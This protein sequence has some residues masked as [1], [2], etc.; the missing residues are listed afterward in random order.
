MSIAQSGKPSSAAALMPPT[1]QAYR[2]V[3]EFGAVGDGVTDD[4]TAIQNAI[5]ASIADGT[6]LCFHPPGRYRI[7]RYIDVPSARNLR[8][9]GCGSTL[10]YP[11]DQVVALDPVVNATGN[12]DQAA[13]SGFLLRHCSNVAIEG[14]VFEGGRHPQIGTL[15]L[16]VGAYVRKS[17]NL[18]IRDS[19]ALW[20][21]TLIVQEAN[22]DTI[23][24]GDALAATD[25]IVTLTDAAAPFVG[26][27]LGM[28]VTVT[29]TVN[30]LNTGRFQITA[31]VSPTQIRFSNE[32]AVT[33][34]SSFTWAIDDA[35]TSTIID[36]CRLINCRGGAITGSN[37][38]WVNCEFRLPLT[39]D[40]TGRATSFAISA[41]TVTLVSPRATWTADMVGK[42]VTIA[43]AA[44]P[45]NNGVFRILT[46]T[47]RT[48]LR[49]G[50]ITYTNGGGVTEL[51]PP[52]MTWWILNGEKTGRGDGDGALSKSGTTMTLTSS[53]NSFASGDIGKTLRIT[54]ATSP[55][56]Q[57]AF[58]ITGVPAANQVTY[59][60][61][62]G[63]AEAFGNGWGLD[64]FDRA[65]GGG[66]AYGSSHAIYYFAGRSHI[67]IE[68]CSF[69]GIRAD[70]IKFS[71]STAPVADVT[72]ANCFAVEC[73]NFVTFGADD[74]Q[75]HTRCLIAGNRIVDCGTGRAG[76]SSQ[77]AVAI[78]GSRD[79]T[80]Q[81]NLLRYTRPAISLVDGR[82][83][84]AGLL[85]ISVSRRT[86]GVSQPVENIA[87]TGNRFVADPMDALADHVVQT[88]IFVGQVGLTA[89]Y[90]T[91]GTLSKAGNVMTLTDPAA[92]FSQELADGCVV[93]LVNSTGGNDITDVAIES[94]AS[95]GASLTYTNAGG[96]G[97]GAR[98]GTYRIQYPIGRRGG[99]CRIAFNEI[100]Q[101]GGTAILSTLNCGPEIVG[102]IVNNVPVLVSETG[103]VSPRIAGNRVVGMSTSNAAIRLNSGT[104]WPVVADNIITVN[105]NALG[106]GDATRGDVGIGVDGGTRVD[107]PLLGTSGRARVSQGKSELVLAYGSGHVDG[108]AITVGGGTFTFKATEPGANQFNTFAGLVA[109]IDNLLAV[110]AS[111]YG[112]ALL[113]SCTTQHI[114]V[115]GA[116][117]SDTVNQFS[118]DTIKTL[119][120]T[121]LV[122]PRNNTGGGEAFQS[123]RGEAT[124][125]AQDK[126][127]IWS[128]CATMSG[129]PTIV[130]NNVAARALLAAGFWQIETPQNPNNAGCCAVVAHG[131]VAATGTEEFRWTLN[132]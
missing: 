2:T 88:P 22:A 14:L 105:G 122:V 49:P 32:A 10:L 77:V 60:N 118:I 6:E 39:N 104:S 46:V 76:W 112:S 53:T 84:V 24:T 44:S 100:D 110:D 121:A 116:V 125:G 58:V 43:N 35:D 93:T 90:G 55:G 59:D 56:N 98:A 27:H 120:P 8:I 109:L 3:G 33:D 37:S 114:R 74:S 51:A 66:D 71:G 38:K 5:D 85:G 102:N 21:R 81:N 18:T 41:S 47:P 101:V 113:P 72:V 123:S 16:G 115:R 57:G 95:N 26:G 67:T 111:D 97:G 68:N 13:R 30:P 64:S 91:G 130:A 69:V 54:A 96:T 127:V 70:A 106:S 99:T 19:L 36:G 63:L 80:I 103:S 79:V 25:G 50:S 73:G 94:V 48:G 78:E 129:G 108:D 42:Y 11:S 86:A 31:V 20:G 40:V 89:R 61:P 9:R 119:N 23:G 12:P 65:D 75:E 124:A 52:A 131:D 62:R 29:D 132:G 87:I 34:A 128:Q 126:T 17:N 45:G 15:N 107:Y 92:R 1:P 117:A 28:F 83:R 4:R 82:A 7:S